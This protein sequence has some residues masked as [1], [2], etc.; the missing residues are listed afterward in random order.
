[1]AT[2]GYGRLHAATHHTISVADGI[3]VCV[4]HAVPVGLW[5]L[6][7]LLQLRCDDCVDVMPTE[8]GIAGGAVRRS[9]SAG[10]LGSGTCHVATV[11]STPLAPLA[12]TH[13]LPAVTVAVTCRPGNASSA[14][15]CGQVVELTDDT[16]DRAVTNNGIWLVKFYAPWCGHCQE[17]AP[18]MEA[19]A[20]D[21]PSQV[22]FGKVDATVHTALKDR[23]GVEGFPTLRY[24]SDGVE[25]K[26]YDLGRTRE[27]LLRFAARISGPV[28]TKV[29][30]KA[31]L[32][33]LAVANG[34][35]FVLCDEV[36]E[37]VQVVEGVPRGSGC[38]R[39]GCMP[40]DCVHV[41]VWLSLVCAGCGRGRCIL[42]DVGLSWDG[43]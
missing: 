39:G 14:S 42:G 16:F 13:P 10:Q 43:E 25:W 21:L 15:A 34:V 11:S 19:A 32:E 1:M 5:F 31:K 3:G 24:T 35:A 9:R 18:V 6:S 2:G 12:R 4:A 28:T 23:F 7:R 37:L 40:H 41:C 22:H 20:K 36:K 27:E 29:D 17:M 30:S 38:H 33:K 26:E 8:P